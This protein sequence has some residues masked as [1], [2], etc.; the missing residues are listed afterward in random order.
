[1]ILISFTPYI[2]E[3]LNKTY[4]SSKVLKIMPFVQLI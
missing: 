1:M 2:H 4:F 3:A